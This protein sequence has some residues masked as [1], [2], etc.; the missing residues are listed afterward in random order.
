MIY[1]LFQVDMY[2][3]HACSRGDQEEYMLLCDGCDDAFHTYF[4]ISPLN[5]IG[6]VSGWYV[7]LSHM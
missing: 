1:L 2:Y 7:L 5:D 4:L 6:L 3:C